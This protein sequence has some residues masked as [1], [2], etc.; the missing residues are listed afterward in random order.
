MPLRFDEAENHLLT[1]A[2]DLNIARR[3]ASFL[4]RGNDIVNRPDSSTHARGFGERHL[5]K[6]IPFV[7][8]LAPLTPYAVVK[9][10]E[11]AL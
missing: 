5:F 11:L 7:L 1:A 4:N 10:A 2:G 8:N 9:R 6:D 3:F